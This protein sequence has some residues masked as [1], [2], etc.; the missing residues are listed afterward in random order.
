MTARTI[1]TAPTEAVGNFNTAAL[2]NGQIRDLNTF[3]LGPPAFYGRQVAS[4][5]VA[6]NTATALTIDTEVY[7][8]DG[9]HSTV[10]NP[11]RVTATIPGWYLVFGYG[12]FVGNTAGSRSVRIYLNGVAVPGSQTTL[13]PAPSGVQWAASCWCMVNVNG[14]TD[15]IELNVSQTSG[16]ALSTYVGVDVDPSLAMWFMSR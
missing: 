9:F 4:Q 15:Y 11:S 12:T 3:A 2:F 6:N 10:T 5:S 13:S 8:S 14:S 7:D 1:P 16:G